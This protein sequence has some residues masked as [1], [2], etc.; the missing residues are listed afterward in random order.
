MWR[1][2][3]RAGECLSLCLRPT[4][5]LY[6][7]TLLTPKQILHM[8]IQHIHSTA[9]KGAVTTFSLHWPH[10]KK[11]TCT[12]VKHWLKVEGSGPAAGH[13]CGVV[14][15]DGWPRGSGVEWW[16]RWSRVQE[17]GVEYREWSG[18]WQPA[19]VPTVLLLPANPTL[20]SATNPSLGTSSHT[21]YTHQPF[22]SHSHLFK[23]RIKVHFKSKE[24]LRK[25]K[26]L[27]ERSD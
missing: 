27:Y 17:S 22:F 12:I 7:F 11:Y 19:G 13:Q 21:C 3:R 15:R 20:R 18:Q 1:L 24:V 25:V 2:C 8:P 10:T 23:G 4:S 14:L 9:F 6:Y 16:R 5:T 26:L